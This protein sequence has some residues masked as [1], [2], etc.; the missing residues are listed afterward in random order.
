MLPNE[1]NKSLYSRAEELFKYLDQFPK[2]TP[3]TPEIAAAEDEL[4]SISVRLF[5]NIL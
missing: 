1:E 2:G 4:D 5:Y 3:E